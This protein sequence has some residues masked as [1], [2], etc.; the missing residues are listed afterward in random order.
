[1]LKNDVK[2]QPFDWSDSVIKETAVMINCCLEPVAL[3]YLAE[4]G[5]VTVC[6]STIKLCK[7]SDDTHKTLIGRIMNIVAKVAKV[8]NACTEIMNSKTLI[9]T[10]LLYYGN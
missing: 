1:M 7:W 8:E 6:E 2:D 10:S 4:Q 9:V 5:V 3:K